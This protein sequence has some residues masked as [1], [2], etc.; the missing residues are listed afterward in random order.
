MTGLIHAELLKLRTLR[1]F[2]WSVVATIAFVP[3]SIA[4]AILA[5]PHGVGPES[6]EGFRNVLSAA[7]SG[8]VLVLLI[9]IIAIAGEFRHNT[10]TS[11]FLITPDR[12]RVIAAKL[13]TTT[14][15]GVALGIVA[16][17][18]S[19]AIALPW[20]ASRDVTLAGHGADI[21]L[22]L[23]GGIA[24]TAVSAVVGVGFGALVTNQTLAITA[25]LVWSFVVDAILVSLLPGVGRWTPGGAASALSSVATANS[26]LLPIWAAAAVFTAYGLAF[27]AVGSRL[28]MHRDIA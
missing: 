15:L 13:A 12:K 23:L 22:V 1:M 26:D 10:I 7:S 18:L 25:A 27:A 4:H 14:L 3:V 24:A 9:G 8:G 2:W 16:S 19:L 21:A 20:L 6:S 28:I 11:T 5:K 17:L